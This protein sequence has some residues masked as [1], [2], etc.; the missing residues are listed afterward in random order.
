MVNTYFGC[1]L[2]QNQLNLFYSSYRPLFFQ[3]IDEK[4]N[5]KLSALQKIIEGTDLSKTIIDKWRSEIC[6]FS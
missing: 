6:C 4:S 5:L 1:L 2:L 3:P